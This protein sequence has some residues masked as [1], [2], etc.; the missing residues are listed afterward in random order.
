M[1]IMSNYIFNTF[2]PVSLPPTP[3]FNP[4]TPFPDPHLPPTI[5]YIHAHE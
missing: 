2:F 4:L 1:V 5:V 3:V